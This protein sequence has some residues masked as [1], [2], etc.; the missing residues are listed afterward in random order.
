VLTERTDNTGTVGLGTTYGFANNTL[1][2]GWFYSNNGALLTNLFNSLV[3]TET[4]T[5][6]LN[7]IDRGDNF[8]DFTQGLDGSLIDV[9]TGPVVQPPAN[10]VA[11]PSRLALLGL[12]LAG[13][14]LS[15]RRKA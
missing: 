13:L 15:R 8:F 12:G 5:F 14:G 10:A 7:D 3:A 4:L 2:T 11:E 1:N 6:G 9:G